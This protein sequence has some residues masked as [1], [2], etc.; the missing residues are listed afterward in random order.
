MNPLTPLL[1]VAALLAP[2]GHAQAETRSFRCKN[3]LVNLGDTKASALLKCGAPL[4]MD[5]F[6]K[7]QPA[8]IVMHTVPVP[9]VPAQ[10]A[11]PTVT[12]VASAPCETV[13]AWTY[14]PGRGQFLTTL[15]FESGQLASISYGD[16]IP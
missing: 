13:D 6:C 11:T 7:P 15:R 14:N 10:P 4:V 5:S 12:V 8:A 1:L 9:T 3:D 2:A 16:R